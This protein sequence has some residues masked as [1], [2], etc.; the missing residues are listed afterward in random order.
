MCHPA[1]VHP[2]RREVQGPQLHVRL[3]E[4]PVLVQRHLQQLGQRFAVIVWLDA[5]AKHHQVRVQ[6]EQIPLGLD[7]DVHTQPPVLELH[8]RPAILVVR[9]ENHALPPR[10]AIVA[11]LESEGADIAIEDAH[12]RLGAALLDRQRILDRLHAADP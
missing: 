9:E 8:L 2:V 3:Q 6:R 5:G 7:H 10:L 4:E 12:L 11:L 1:Q